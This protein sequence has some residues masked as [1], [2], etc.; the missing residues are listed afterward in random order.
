MLILI[1]RKNR[2]FI[3]T[4]DKA[5]FR[6]RKIIRGKQK[7]Y[8]MM[9]G[10]ILPEDTTVLNMYARDNRSSKYVGQ[11]CKEKYM[12]PLSQLAVSIPLFQ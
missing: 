10:S 3:L 6:A 9:R 11:N 4:S 1:K 7:H 8:L 5:N 12:D 2:N